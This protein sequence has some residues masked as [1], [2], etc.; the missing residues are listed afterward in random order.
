MKIHKI[1]KILIILTLC[2]ALACGNANAAAS[3]ALKRDLQTNGIYLVPPSGAPSGSLL[4]LARYGGG[5]LLQMVSAG[6]TDARTAAITD[7]AETDTFKGF[8]WKSFATIQPLTVT[9]KASAGGIDPAE[10]N[11]TLSTGTARVGDT[12]TAV[13][14]LKNIHAQ[15]VTVPIHF[16]PNVV[17]IAQQN[18][19]IVPSG[20][21]TSAEIR[22]GTAGVTLGEALT[23]G[24]WDGGVFV[25]PVYPYL[26][27][28]NGFYRLLFTRNGAQIILNE[29][30]LTL[31]FTTV[32][33]GE[34][35]IRFA[36][37]ADEK[38]DE[39]SPLGV[40][41]VGEAMTIRFAKGTA[42]GLVVEL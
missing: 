12:V 19:N 2:A 42:E 18:G 9:E 29:T 30:L 22:N 24:H 17:R 1:H 27:N 26:D 28:E 23:A 37:D 20:N 13:V 8:L 31:C 32:G 14:T 5:K 21:K 35:D 6:G 34:A 38:Y 15:M 10:A 3:V 16:N 25:N 41:Y 7:Y 11:I 36:T 33:G 40:S 4:I 39:Q